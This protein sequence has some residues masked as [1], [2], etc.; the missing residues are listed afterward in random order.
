VTI[1]FTAGVSGTSVTNLPIVSTDPA[2]PSATVKAT[3]KV[4]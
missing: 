4:R 2:R 1:E 3:A